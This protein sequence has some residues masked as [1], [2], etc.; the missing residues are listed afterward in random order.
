VFNA[1]GTNLPI[2]TGNLDPNKAP[3]EIFNSSK[4]KITLSSGS[5]K[6]EVALNNGLEVSNQCYTNTNDEGMV[7]ENYSKDAGTTT[8][9]TYSTV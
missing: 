2:P 3:S 5:D 1:E 4:W 8:T 9:S 7:F 6:S